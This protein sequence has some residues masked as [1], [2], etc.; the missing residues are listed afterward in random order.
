MAEHDS[1]GEAQQQA[2]QMERVL[3]SEPVLRL[4]DVQRL[5]IPRTNASGIGLGGVLL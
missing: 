2:F 3:C 4:P 5:F 1:L